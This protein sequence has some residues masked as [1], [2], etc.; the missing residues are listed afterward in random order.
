MGRRD[1]GA[2]SAGIRVRRASRIGT[3]AIIFPGVEIGAEA[4]VGAASLVRKDVPARTVVAG[5]PASVL[6]EVRDDELLE[7]W[8]E[9]A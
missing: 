8:H 7:R 1:A 4:V 9:P 2:E 3:A 5:S 6:R